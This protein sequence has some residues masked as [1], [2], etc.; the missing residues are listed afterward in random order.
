[1]FSVFAFFV[2]EGM[3]AIKAIALALAV[4]VAVDAFWSDLTL[5]GNVLRG[6]D[7]AFTASGTSGAVP[8][9]VANRFVRNGDAVV[10]EQ[11]GVALGDDVALHNA[12][13]GI[14]APDAVDLGGN[15]ARGNGHDPQCVGV[16][17]TPTPTS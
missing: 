12:G 6:N 16:S 15:T 4:G 1:M 9:L 10:V 2:P 17:C 13:W 14:Y 3:G 8:T 11:P 5:T 7:L